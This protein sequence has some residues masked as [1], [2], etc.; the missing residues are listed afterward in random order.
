MAIWACGWIWFDEILN[1]LCNSETLRPMAGA[2]MKIMFCS[3]LPFLLSYMLETFVIVDGE[4][5]W[6]TVAV[7]VGNVKNIILDIL[8]IKVFQ[9]GVEGAAVATM[10]MYILSTVMLVGHFMRKR[11]GATCLR[12]DSQMKMCSFGQIVTMGLPVTLTTFLI[13]VQIAV[14]NW[15]AIRYLG[16]TG[17]VTFAVCIALLAFSMIFVSGT[18]R[19]IQPVGAIL[20]GMRDARGVILMMGRAYR[21]LTLSLLIL[22]GLILVIPELVAALFGVKEAAMQSIVAQA[23]PVFAINIFLEGVY[24]LL[25]PAYQ[26]YNHNKLALF[27]A[28]AKAILSMLGFW[29][30]ASC[31][32]PWAWWGFALGQVAMGLIL[33]PITYHLRKQNGA[34]SKVLLIPEEAA[35]SVMDISVATKIDQIQSA[36]STLMNFLAENGISESRCNYSALCLE[37]LLKNIIDHGHAHFVDVR[38][39]VAEQKIS[40]SLHDDGVAFNPVE[41]IEQD[42]IGLT[43]VRKISC[44]M[45]YEYLFNQNMI[46]ITLAQ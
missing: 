33:F 25:I 19:T 37:E 14:C 11:N 2:Y 26:F 45:K 3:M 35:S 31:L 39:L 38:G 40:I 16:D 32:T 34:L 23:L 20:K 17:V 1:A 13:A 6:A 18:M 28:L 42:Q 30:M 21:F 22:C 24:S 4:P 5:R 46:T 27:V 29:W 15:L 36:T 8:F 9:W 10:I 43:L 7:V 12:W 41:H 44:D